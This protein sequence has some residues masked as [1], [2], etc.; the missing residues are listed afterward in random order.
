N[1]LLVFFDKTPESPDS[2]EGGES[3]KKVRLSSD[4]MTS[5][6]QAVAGDAL[7]GVFKSL[8]IE[9]LEMDVKAVHNKKKSEKS[10]DLM[11]ESEKEKISK[12]ASDIK[13]L[14]DNKFYSDGNGEFRKDLA[15]LLSD[16]FQEF[17]KL[18]DDYTI[19]FLDFYNKY[20]GAPPI[21]F[22]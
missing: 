3:V 16:A 20:M 22:V 6:A 4:V 10:K 1:P 2:S 13:F 8:D 21:D 14:F 12:M 15:D 11:I 5:A 19:A 9:G 7:M 17:N 18:D